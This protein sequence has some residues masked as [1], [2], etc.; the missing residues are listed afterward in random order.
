MFFKRLAIPADLAESTSAL[1]FSDQ[2]DTPVAPIGVGDDR[3]T[4]LGLETEAPKSIDRGEK[5]IFDGGGK[6]GGGGLT[7][8]TDLG[9]EAIIKVIAGVRMGDSFGSFPAT[10]DVSSLWSGDSSSFI[11]QR[12]PNPYLPVVAVKGRVFAS[13]AFCF[14]TPFILL[15]LWA[16]L[17]N[18]CFFWSSFLEKGSGAS[19][20][21]RELQK[22][23]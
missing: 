13:A 14:F 12:P 16:F 6:I 18:F 9:K 20:V 8:R 22:F 2:P 21:R 3:G 17:S 7:G 5:T 4:G 15:A 23:V 19:S 10:S 1:V 11:C